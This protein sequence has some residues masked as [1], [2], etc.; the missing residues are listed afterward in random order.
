MVWKGVRSTIWDVVDTQHAEWACGRF[1]KVPHV[2]IRI[3]DSLERCSEYGLGCGRY[4]ACGMGLWTVWKGT[5]CMN[6][7]CGYFGKVPK[8]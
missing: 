3:V 4:A 8:V 6:W 7:D 2:R 1:G 5:L